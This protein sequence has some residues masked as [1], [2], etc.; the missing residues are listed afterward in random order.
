MNL[1]FSP[2]AIADNSCYKMTILALFNCNRVYQT[3]FR[4]C[5]NSAVHI[6]MSHS[7]NVQSL[8]TIYNYIIKSGDVGWNE[9]LTNINLLISS[10]QFLTMFTMMTFP[11][12]SPNHPTKTSKALTQL[13]LREVYIYDNLILSQKCVHD[14]R[15]HLLISQVFL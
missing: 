3:C 11:H 5:C 15:I 8:L 6:V 1:N 12:H 2:T 7:I 9:I 4:F 10:M 13:T 14:I